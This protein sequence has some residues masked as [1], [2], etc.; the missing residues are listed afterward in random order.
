[1]NRKI[2]LPVVVT[3]L[4]IITGYFVVQ[5]NSLPAYWCRPYFDFECDFQAQLACEGG[6]YFE[7][8]FGA[9]CNGNTCRSGY[10]IWCEVGGNWENNGA[11][12]CDDPGGCEVN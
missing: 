8:S 10:V 12:Y 5:V 1:M 7:V 2:F 11:I 3:F 9:W 6:E 4:V